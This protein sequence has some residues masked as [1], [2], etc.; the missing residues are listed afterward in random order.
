MSDV[1][2]WIL[3]PLAGFLAG[4]IPFGFIVARARGVDIRTVGSGNIGMT[5]VW[6]ALGW[7]AGATVLVLD[8]LKGIAPTVGSEWYWHAQV[9]RLPGWDGSGNFSVLPLAML[10]GL[11]AVLGHT[12]TPWLGFK[13]GKGIATGAG[14]FVALLKLWALVPV[15]VFVLALAATRMVSVGSLL[16]AW[17]G[18][19]LT[20]AVP[21]MRLLFPLVGLLAVFVTWTHREN[22]QRIRSGTERRI[23][24]G[25]PPAE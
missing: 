22:I 2:T 8:L 23:G 15:G 16:G 1:L 13:G 6:R 4:S 10:T 21:Q 7:K 14:V 12:F 19:I 3:W 25:K 9:A 5:N 18:V 24:E 17:S 11:L 20:L